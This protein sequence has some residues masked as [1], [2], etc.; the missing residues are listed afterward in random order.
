MKRKKE[1]TLD[2][3][4]GSRY[5]GAQKKNAQHAKLQ[6]YYSTVCSKDSQM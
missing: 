3:G 4:L 5:I 6:Y 1:K 2:P